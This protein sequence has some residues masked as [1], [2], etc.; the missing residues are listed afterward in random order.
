MRQKRSRLAQQDTANPYVDDARQRADALI[1][2]N[3]QQ[4]RARDEQDDEATKAEEASAGRGGSKGHTGK[5]SQGRSGE[6]AI[7]LIGEDVTLSPL[8]RAGGRVGGYGDGS[9]GRAV[10]YDPS[11]APAYLD[12]V[13][14]KY[15]INPDD[16]KR[17]AWIESKFDTG[18]RAGSSSAGGLFQFTDDT[19]KRYGLSNKFDGYANADAA[20]RLWLDN[21]AGLQQALGREPTAG[22]LYLAHQQGLGGA[23]KLLSN[24]NA[25]AENLLGSDAFRNNGGRAG[26]TGA[27][28]AKLWTGKFDAALPASTPQAGSGVTTPHNSAYVDGL[29]T[30]YGGKSNGESQQCV[31]L[32]KEATNVGHTS[33]WQPGSGIDASTKPGTPI[34]TFG[35][36]GKY[37]NTPGESHAAIYLGPGSEP[38]SIRVFDQWKGHAAG[39]REIKPGVGPEG[40][41]NF[42]VINTRDGTD[43]GIAKVPGYGREQA[44]AIPTAPTN[45]VAADM[46]VMNDASPSRQQMLGGAPAPREDMTNSYNTKLSP[47]DEQKFQA[48]AKANGREKDTFDYD[49]RGFWK[50]GAAF[51]DNGHGS[52]EW[53]KPNHPTFS[54]E[55]RYN[56][57]DGFT[58]GRWS[59]DGGH[60]SFTPSETN[61][62]NMPN[63]SMEKY[64]GEREPSVKLNTAIPLEGSGLSLSPIS[65]N[66]LKGQKMAATGPVTPAAS[67]TPDTAAIP[68]QARG[69]MP[70]ATTPAG[71]HYQQ[72]GDGPNATF[73]LIDDKTK[74][75]V[76]NLSG[77]PSASQGAKDA[78]A[79]QPA[80]PQ[81]T[82]PATTPTTTP[83][84]TNTAQAAVPLP[85]RRPTDLGANSE[86]S[87]GSTGSTGGAGGNAGHSNNQQTAQAQGPLEQFGGWLSDLFNVPDNYNNPNEAGQ[88]WDPLY[89]N[90]TPPAETA[91]ASN[92]T[93]GS[94]GDMGGDFFG[95]IGNA[96]GG[97]FGFERGGAVPVPSRPDR[98]ASSQPGVAIPASDRGTA[99]GGGYNARVALTPGYALGGPVS[100]LEDV[101]GVEPSNVPV[102]ER[103]QYADATGS[104]GIPVNDASRAPA[105]SA[106]PQNS[107]PSQPSEPTALPTGD[108][109]A[110]SIAIP[111]G[112]ADWNKYYRPD[113]VTDVPYAPNSREAQEQA[114][115]RRRAI[116]EQER[117]RQQYD[118][119]SFTFGGLLRNALHAAITGVQET[120]DFDGM[121]HKANSQALPTQDSDPFAELANFFG[122]DHSAEAM[123][124]EDVKRLN[125]AVDPH[126]KLKSGIATTASLVSG[127]EYALQHG[128]PASAKNFAV[129]LVWHL[130]NQAA[131]YGDEALGYL[132]TGDTDEGIKSLQKAYDATPDG[133]TVRVQKNDDGTVR[134]QQV[135]TQ[136]GKVTG[137]MN[138]S[139][140]DL[141][142]AATGMKSGTMFWQQIMAAAQG[143]AAMDG[144]QNN[145]AFSDWAAQAGRDAD[146]RGKTSVP[147]F[148]RG[149]TPTVPDDP[150]L[151]PV[152]PLSGDE[153]EKLG[154]VMP[155]MPNRPPPISATEL[156]PLNAKDRAT[157]IRQRTAEQRAWDVEA[158]AKR[159]DYTRAVTEAERLHRIK[160]RGDNQTA[161]DASK[162]EQKK[163]DDAAKADARLEA[164]LT[165]SEN[166]SAFKG[167]NSYWEDQVDPTG[168]VPSQQRDDTLGLA[169][170]LMANRRNQL[171]P[172]D[173][174]RIG[175]MLTSPRDAGI[176]LT[177]DKGHKLLVLPDG[178]KV[179]APQSVIDWRNGFAKSHSLP[180][181]SQ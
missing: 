140:A 143:K 79:A 85:P 61:R 37:M 102:E 46:S 157:V 122:G 69:S 121:V 89:G 64:F 62:A 108:A 101:L 48:W 180:E 26:M 51:S 125:R 154:I 129:S 177:E 170:S 24:P 67:T 32:V 56:G 28:F 110:Q 109:P 162:A 99:P 9:T 152:P 94:A 124:A 146:E 104:A 63:G 57:A 116:A 44:Q 18:A 43:P 59:N 130:Q 142:A 127:Y 106:T 88:Q 30:S 150:K 92:D 167:L 54:V 171:T 16:F 58:G 96:L 149:R 13:A 50:S 158:D 65:D 52:D 105:A 5:R 175:S 82:T 132:R 164:P 6:G 74:A 123:P 128:D 1:A 29:V 161:R 148:E 137:T 136:T 118:E 126:E 178:R 147:L 21:K 77:Y 55:S 81:A 131:R 114:Y 68:L 71:T 38:G 120:N 27:D 176:K 117:V 39:V 95:G 20:A 40:A 166:A 45:K 91:S 93:G 42:R 76:S 19:A 4:M 7:P 23:T 75:P 159:K 35:E 70:T 31:A 8:D 73:I 78:L 25:S 112:G 169:H 133:H 34:A 22:E 86:S 80:T 49:L 173:A 33:N 156:A 3:A 17:M 83:A 10:Q 138:A 155:S 14:K 100:P 153:L 141:L 165:P 139:E 111:S 107:T 113:P 87:D 119:N 41:E 160:I 135:D 145:A 15:G 179:H 60:I 115:E 12:D 72:Y 84:A 2:R 47:D 97:M 144:G 36:G 172:A 151:A 134:V 11:K 163:T 174:I 103:A 181:L 90:Q 98:V 66:N 53:K 168:R